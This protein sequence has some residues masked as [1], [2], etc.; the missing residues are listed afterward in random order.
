M[1][2]PAFNSS[3]IPQQDN[4]AQNVDANPFSLLFSKNDKQQTSVRPWTETDLFK[5]GSAEL[6]SDKK[7]GAMKKQPVDIVVHDAGI[8]STSDDFN[9]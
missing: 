3:R 8:S 6:F 4:S 2:H 5:G 7:A 1:V 9:R